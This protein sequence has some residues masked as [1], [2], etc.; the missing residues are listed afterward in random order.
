MWLFMCSKYTVQKLAFLTL[1]VCLFYNLVH[2]LVIS[3]VGQL[4]Q[5]QS[6]EQVGGWDSRWPGYVALTSECHRAVIREYVGVEE[7]SGF[8]L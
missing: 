5:H 4:C 7:H 1:K 6:C 3:E 2:T 8:P